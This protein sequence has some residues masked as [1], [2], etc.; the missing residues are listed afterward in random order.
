MNSCNLWLPI[1]ISFQQMNKSNPTKNE[2]EF[3]DG[4][5]EKSRHILIFFFFINIKIFLLFFL[6]RIRFIFAETNCLRR[7]SNSFRESWLV[8]HT[9]Y[10]HFDFV[11]FSSF[12]HLLPFHTLSVSLTVKC[13]KKKNKHYSKEFEV[14]FHI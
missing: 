13:P 3:T 4:K 2:H 8:I 11:F 7:V 6:C 10:F 12:F 5:K 9:K 14:S 1:V